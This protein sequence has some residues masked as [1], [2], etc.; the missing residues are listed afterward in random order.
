MMNVISRNKWLLFLLGILLLANILLLLY[1]FVFGKGGQDVRSG[2]TSSYVTKKLNLSVEQEARFKEM[3]E[4]YL[5]TMRP[6]WDDIRR[7]KDSLYTHLGDPMLA[8]STIIGLTNLIA[9]NNRKSDEQQFRHFRELRK[10]CTPAQQATFDTLIP[11]MLS[12]M[13]GRSHSRK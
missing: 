4:A 12:R 10:L 11:R 2:N 3:K 7:S 8:D 1:I 9:E 13:G 5:K 6:L